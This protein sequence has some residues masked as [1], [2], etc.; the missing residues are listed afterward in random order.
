[1]TRHV[2]SSGAGRG[3][4]ALLPLPGRLVRPSLLPLV[5]WEPSPQS[6]LSSM[7][8]YCCSIR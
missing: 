8:L 2:S 4:P 6:W 3:G 1:M 7:Q 5:G